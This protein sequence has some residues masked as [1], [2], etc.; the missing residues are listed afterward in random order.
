[1]ANTIKLTGKQ[2]STK[3]SNLLDKILANSGISYNLGGWRVV[4]NWPEIVGNKIGQ[5]SKAIRFE[6]ETLLISVPDSIWRQ[7]LSL[8][9]DAILEKIHSTPGG[10]AVKKIHFVS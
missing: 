4:V 1:M 5:A 8:E 10:K 2:S 3:L 9:T 7:Q 6:N